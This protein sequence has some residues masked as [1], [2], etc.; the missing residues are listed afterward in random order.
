MEQLQLMQDNIIGFECMDKSMDLFFSILNFKPK[1][2]YYL[3]VEDKL[4]HIEEL[5]NTLSK[6][7]VLAL[8]WYSSKRMGMRLAPTIISS[9]MSIDKTM[10]LEEKDKLKFIIEDTFTTPKFIAD[11]VVY[12]KE[13]HDV[14]MGKIPPF[15]K[16]AFKKQ[17][18]SY[19]DIT[20]KKNKLNKGKYSKKCTL[21]DMIKMFRPNPVISKSSLPIFEKVIECSKDV[22]LTN[23]TVSSILS[24]SEM[25]QE[26]K[27]VAIEKNLSNMSINEIVRNIS[28]IPYTDENFEIVSNK[29]YS[30]I[31]NP[32]GIRILNPYDLV[33]TEQSNVDNR[34]LDLF[35][36]VLI[37][38]MNDNV[39]KFVRDF[40]FLIDISWSM[41]GEGQKS[42]AKF[43]SLLRV[44]CKP[45]NVFFYGYSLY[46]HDDIVKD[47]KEID[48]PNKLF[49]AVFRQ[50]NSVSSGG[51]ETRKCTLEVLRKS[52]NSLV[53]VTDEF[54]YDSSLA[55]TDSIKSELQ[56]RQM[57][58]FNTC[59]S[60]SGAFSFELGILRATGFQAQ[61]FQV[62]ALM[63]NFTFFKN[64]V[65]SEFNSAYK[66]KRKI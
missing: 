64:Q 52:S 63:N 45:K 13:R 24:N 56:D 65:I 37:K 51:T 34:W 25:T 35:D 58:L 28:N 18:E 60:G 54:S 42:C 57:I 27:R 11:S 36:D 10:T 61:L 26:E 17:L 41:Y 31:K 5:V 20:L 47:F 48:R 38:F 21:A 55:F 43:L 12:L 19:S 33:I 14:S 2:S 46:N 1:N 23:E 44:V 59:W 53:L 22:S 7:E 16:K 49:K 3:S 8:T 4:R 6:E 62:F 32:N 39:A 30:T 15:L 9:L 40:D 29:L 50:L 66:F